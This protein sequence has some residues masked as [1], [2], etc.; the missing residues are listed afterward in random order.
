MVTYKYTGISKDGVKVHGVVEAFNEL[1]A[2]ERIRESCEIVTKMTEVKEKKQSILSMEIGG[3]KLN[4]KAFTMMCSQFYIIL[5][6]GIPIARTVRLIA[7]KMTDKPLRKLLLQTAKDVEAGR[8]LAQSLEERGKKLFPVTFIE[9]IRAGELSGNL[10]GAF[11]N[12]YH[13][14][15]RQMK[16]GAKVRNALIY[17]IFVIL[18]AIA[19]VIVLM[20]KVVPTFTEM[21]AG[22]GADLPLITRILIAI[23][24]FFQKNIL[25]MVLIAAVLTIAYK[26]YTNTEN[27][28]MR[29]ARLSLNLPVLGNVHQ[30]NAAS[31][32]ANTLM[33]LISAG[34]PITHAISITARVMDN[35]F[36]GHEI[37]TVA[38][39]LEEGHMLGESLRETGCM[40][41]ILVD[42]VAV[43]EETGELETTLRTIGNYY[44]NE[45]EMAIK[46]ALG[47]L[48]PSVLLFIAAIAAFIV[49][50]VYVAM[51]EM[52]GVM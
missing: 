45:L 8:S 51:F 22:Y 19:V 35:Y 44:D 47:K 14:Y 4:M 30:L 16:T 27:G 34:Q 28:R 52:Y 6:S 3:N 48:E 24:E 2:V 13:H 7:D 40:P 10:D 39:R 46:S 42:M 29:I 1:D 37:G 50:A 21:F 9:T 5:R 41:D 11:E 15:D 38:R 12:M 17:P 36:V 20:V 23:S 33:T 49:L 25:W 43:G 31:Q 18:V 32:F 26:I